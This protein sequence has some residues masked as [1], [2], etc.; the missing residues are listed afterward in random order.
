MTL[1]HPIRY[2]Y[3]PVLVRYQLSNVPAWSKIDCLLKF[4]AGT[5]KVATGIKLVQ[6]WYYYLMSLLGWYW[7]K[8]SAQGIPA[9]LS[10]W[11]WVHT[12]HCTLF[13]SFNT[14]PTFL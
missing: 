12:P 14:K 11:I 9:W 7:C 4:E 3:E 1:K 13:T 10:A 6:S 8:A 2:L 5:P